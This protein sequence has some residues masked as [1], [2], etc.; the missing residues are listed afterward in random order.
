MDNIAKQIG[1]EGSQIA[2]QIGQVTESTVSDIQQRIADR[3]KRM[4]SESLPRQEYEDLMKRNVA[5]H[6][7]L[8]SYRKS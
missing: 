2:Q 1:H 7:K 3:T 5:D 6:E 8:A 4:L